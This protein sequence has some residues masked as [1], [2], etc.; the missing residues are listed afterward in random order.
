MTTFFVLLGLGGVVF[1]GLAI[2]LVA[3]WRRQ[4]SMSEDDSD[5]G[6]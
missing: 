5:K 1:A 6:E 2:W 3:A 4:E